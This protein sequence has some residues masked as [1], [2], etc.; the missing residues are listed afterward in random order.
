MALIPFGGGGLAAGNAVA[1]NAAGALVLSA[2]TILNKLYELNERF[3]E[4]MNQN[5]RFRIDRDRYEAMLANQ[6]RLLNG[7][8]DA[9]LNAPLP[10]VPYR[11]K[12]YL[13]Y[14]RRRRYRYRRFRRYSSFRRRYFRR[15][16]RYW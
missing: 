1:T 11:N 14:F 16:R 12:V 13:R 15:A 5:A 10:I 8:E 6:R 9:L 7:T 3:W 4:G 2:P